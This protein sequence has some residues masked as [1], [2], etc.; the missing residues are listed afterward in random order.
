M[1]ATRMR[2]WLV[3]KRKEIDDMAERNR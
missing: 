1:A 3:E 2:P